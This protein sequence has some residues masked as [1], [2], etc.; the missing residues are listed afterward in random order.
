MNVYFINDSPTHVAVHLLL[1]AAALLPHVDTIRSDWARHNV[2]GR[3]CGQKWQEA[4][5]MS[6]ARLL[7]PCLCGRWHQNA[8]A[9]DVNSNR[10]T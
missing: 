2:S 10:E 7:M 1:Y 6:E 5:P 4:P 9:T 8:N 3:P